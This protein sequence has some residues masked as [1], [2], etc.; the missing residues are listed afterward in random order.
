M[1]WRE[2]ADGSLVV[3]HGGRSWLAVGLVIAGLGLLAGS[4]Y[5]WFEHLSV[6]DKWA[7]FLGGGA[8]CL[9]T[10]LALAEKS[11][12][13]FDRRRRTLEWERTH[14]WAKKAGSV[15]FDQ[16]RQVRAERP[17]GDDGAPSRRIVLS[18]ADGTSVPLRAA[19]VPDGDGALEQLA[20]RIRVVLGGTPQPPLGDDVAALV[21]QGRKI[22]AIKLVRERTGASLLDAKNEVD[23]LEARRR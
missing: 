4:A 21:A 19:Y 12:F 8:T 18:L 15:A 22:A 16:V 1:D 9:I 2:E 23:A 13:V 14:A 20:Q 10:G 7:G 5:D 6:D 17:I 3:T 11:R